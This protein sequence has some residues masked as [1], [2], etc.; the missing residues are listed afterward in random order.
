[1][2]VQ[3]VNAGPERSS[4]KLFIPEG[5]PILTLVSN[6]LSANSIL[7]GNSEVPPVIIVFLLDIS[8]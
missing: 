8:L 3:E 4:T 5:N 7:P 2:P 6:I 1:M